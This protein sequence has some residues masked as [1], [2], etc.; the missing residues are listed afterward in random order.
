MDI[1][2]S[3]QQPTEEKKLDDSYEDLKPEVFEF[4]I[5]ITEPSIQKNA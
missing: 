4:K 2:E 1:E 3:K 5:E